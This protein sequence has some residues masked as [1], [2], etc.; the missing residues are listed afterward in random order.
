MEEAKT[1]TGFNTSKEE[2]ISSITI[3]WILAYFPYFLQKIKQSYKI[4]LLYMCLC[5]SHNF[6]IFCVVR[7]VSKESRQLVCSRTSCYLLVK[8][9]DILLKFRY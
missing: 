6:L 1:Y 5:N 7:V 9:A 4:T 3:G 8:S 2:K